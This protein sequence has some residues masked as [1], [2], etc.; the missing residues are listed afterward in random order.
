MTVVWNGWTTWPELP[1][2]IIEPVPGVRLR[3]RK[4][5]NVEEVFSYLVREYHA[6][7]DDLT[8][9]HPM[10]DWGFNYRPNKNNPSKL[11]KHGFGLAIDLDATEHPNGISIGKTFS[12]KQIAEIHEILAE[13]DGILIWGGDFT[14]TV[15][16]M[17]FEVGVSPSE[18]S[19][20]WSK[21]KNDP[22]GS[23]PEKPSPKPVTKKKSEATI[24]REVLA[25]LWGN[26][27][28]RER[29]LAKAG[30]NPERIQGLVNKKLTTQ[31]STAVVVNEVLAG[32]WGN[33]SVRA[34]RLKAAGYNPN[35]I[36]L[37]VNRRLK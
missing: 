14:H 11:S 30:Y 10:D 34:A 3:V 37:E 2:T 33:G 26:G 4:D 35:L 12:A 18:L 36:Q 17:H 24:V 28:D 6:R 13:L 19:R 27:K 9:P 21:I 25:G 29:R 7:V 16:G 32:K 15:D 5:K 31:K 20:R 8:K 22:K 1:T 23:R